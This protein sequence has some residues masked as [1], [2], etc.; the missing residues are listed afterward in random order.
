MRRDV[1]KQKHRVQLVADS[2]FWRDVNK[3]SYTFSVVS[4]ILSSHLQHNHIQRCSFVKLFF[5]VGYAESGFGEE[6]L[7]LL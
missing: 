1:K 2:G 7:V 5:V 3:V 4:Q 6:A